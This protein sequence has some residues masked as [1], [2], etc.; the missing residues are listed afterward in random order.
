MIYGRIEDPY[1]EFPIVRNSHIGPSTDSLLTIISNHA[2]QC[3][4]AV[5]H[6]PSSPTGDHMTVNKHRLE[7][8]S[9]E[10]T[11]RMTTSRYSLDLQKIPSYIPIQIMEYVLFIGRVSCAL[12]M[13][14]NNNGQLSESRLE[15]ME[16]TLKE[17]LSSLMQVDH[18]HIAHFEQA[19][20]QA[21]S[22]IARMVWS[23]IVD[24]AGLIDHL[25]LIRQ[26][27][28][29]GCGQMGQ[30]LIKAFHHSS[31]I[32]AS[33]K[34]SE[35]HVR[36]I[37]RKLLV[38]LLPENHEL[39]RRLSL[40]FIDTSTITMLEDEATYHQIRA[41]GWE[42]RL[43]LDYTFDWPLDL[44]FSTHLIDK[45]NH[46]F[47]FVL[48]IRRVQLTLRQTWKYQQ[49]ANRVFIAQRDT[50]WMEIWHLRHHMTIFI[51]L[52]QMYLQS[53]VINTNHQHLIEAIG[54]TRDFEHLSITLD[55][56]LNTIISQCFL[57]MRSI[58]QTLYDLFDE[59]ITFCTYIEQFAVWSRSLFP[60]R[61]EFLR[62]H[63]GFHRHISLLFHTFS[64]V[65]ANLNNPHLAHFLLRLDFNHHYSKSSVN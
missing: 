52:L 45:Y 1:Q 4:D 16:T 25:H 55:D 63:D 23:W 38:K 32:D 36:G 30:E 21:N 14:T 5:P 2:Q 35:K 61:I 9:N 62:F 15:A 44:L 22:N 54:N 43:Y 26:I 31:I 58:R 57:H 59:I 50:I 53:E 39:I 37:F 13:T 17:T 27:Y 10:T 40:K 51:D 34:V 7:P 42:S 12:R 47:R 64:N 19:I 3:P 48:A 18:F 28:F 33:T 24:E 29:L 60:D 11:N 41:Y 56:H 8:N 49:Q 6:L 46:I 20:A 65:Q